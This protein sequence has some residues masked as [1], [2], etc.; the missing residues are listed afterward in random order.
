MWMWRFMISFKMGMLAVAVMLG[1]ALAACNT[2]DETACDN[3]PPQILYELDGL[4]DM[5]SRFN[6]DSATPRLLLLMS[7]T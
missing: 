1:L 2:A 6:E 3:S 7:P 4:D 5:K